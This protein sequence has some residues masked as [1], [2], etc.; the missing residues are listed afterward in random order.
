[1]LLRF[2]TRNP[3]YI[4]N[5]KMFANLRIVSAGEVLEK[6]Q[7]NGVIVGIK[8]ADPGFDYLFALG[9]SGLS[10]AYGGPNSHMAIR[11]SEFGIPAVI[12]IGGEQFKLLKNGRAIAIDCRARRY[13]QE[14]L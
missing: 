4:S 14:A 10:T 12:G 2:P 6:R 3:T 7:A 13:S 1:M 11:A 5:R 9:I 8:N